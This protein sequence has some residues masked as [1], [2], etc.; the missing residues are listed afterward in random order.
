MFWDNRVLS[1]TRATRLEGVSAIHPLHHTCSNMRVDVL[2]PYISGLAWSWNYLPS[3]VREPDDL[4]NEVISYRANSFVSFRLELQKLPWLY[5]LSDR[6]WTG[7]RYYS[8]A[9][10][11]KPI[12]HATTFSDVNIQ[13]H[14]NQLMHIRLTYLFSYLLTYLLIYLLIYLFIYLLTYLLT[15]LRTDIDEVATAVFSFLWC[16]IFWLLF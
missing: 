8:D 7:V 1:Q 3:E 5:A 11:L 12:Y 6:V 9:N 4:L 2:L 13:P 10:A 16:L 15:Y 14:D